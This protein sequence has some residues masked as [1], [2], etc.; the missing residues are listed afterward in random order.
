MCLLLTKLA[1]V[2]SVALA[3]TFGAGQGADAQSGYQVR[4]GDTLQVE[5]LED[6]SLNRAVLV[7]PDGSISFPLVG[8]LQAAGSSVAQLQLQIAAGLAS[9]FAVA[10]NVFVSVSTLAERKPVHSGPRAPVTI[11]AYIVGEVNSPGKIDVEPGTTIL[12]L[13]AEAGGLT[14]FAAERRIE[15]RRNNPATGGEETYF[16]S[17]TGRGRWGPLIPG[18]TVLSSGDVVVVP[19][20]RLLE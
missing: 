9:N 13:L 10:P 16:F 1:M 20:R 15:L 4:P 18:S 7:L 19:K 5:V 8:T 2:I 6:S 11:K 17:Y 14:T 3:L 12:Q